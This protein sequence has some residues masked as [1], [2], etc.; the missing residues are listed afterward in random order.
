VDE[1]A[2]A[3]PRVEVVEV[4]AEVAQGEE[5]RRPAEEVL[6][7]DVL[8]APVRGEAVEVVLDG[9]AHAGHL[10]EGAQELDGPGEEGLHE[11]L[12]V[13]GEVVEGRILGAVEDL[14]EAHGLAELFD[15]AVDLGRALRVEAREEAAVVL[16]APG[17]REA[18]KAVLDPDRDRR[19]QEVEGEAEA[20]K[21]GAHDARV[22]DRP[23]P[24]VEA[25]APAV[26]GAH[27]APDGLVALEEEDGAARLG[28]EGRGRKA[29]HSPAHDD[30]VVALG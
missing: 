3:A 9:P 14:H 29:G 18:D 10:P 4:E 25:E 24:R 6:A 7:D 23:E 2:R 30:A 27:E 1:L 11:V 12:A 20:L 28:D 21:E 22:L 17:A 26:D 5:G 8:Q 16:E 15:D 13:A 19:G